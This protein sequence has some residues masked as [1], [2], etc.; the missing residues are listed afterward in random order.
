MTRIT[1][2]RQ[3]STP[4]TQAIYETLGSLSNNYGDGNENGK[5]KLVNLD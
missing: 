2:Q 3:V 4:V 5:K 1:S